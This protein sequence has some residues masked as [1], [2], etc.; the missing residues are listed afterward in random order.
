MTL[1]AW[2]ETHGAWRAL[3]A[4]GMIK[5]TTSQEIVSG[6]AATSGQAGTAA[7][8]GDFDFVAARHTLPGLGLQRASQQ[9][10]VLFSLI[11][12]SLTKRQSLLDVS[13]GLSR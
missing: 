2:H 13:L 11:L 3:A 4:V 7:A 5:C 8:G 9:L 10:E 12:L 1:T 6:V